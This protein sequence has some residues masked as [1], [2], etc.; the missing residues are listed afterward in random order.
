ML[1]LLQVDLGQPTWVYAVASQNSP[2]GFLT[3]DYN[4]AT[5]LDGATFG[6]I[7]NGTANEVC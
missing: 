2:G 6:F 4:L 1:P 7:K 3:L 5:S